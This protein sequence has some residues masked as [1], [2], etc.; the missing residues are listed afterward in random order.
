MYTKGIRKIL[1][2]DEGWYGN[3]NKLGTLAES[4]RHKAILHNGTVYV[5]IG[6]H[7]EETP[8]TIDDFSDSDSQ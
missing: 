3:I 4:T 5:K 7:W 1:I 8:F 2:L 6:K